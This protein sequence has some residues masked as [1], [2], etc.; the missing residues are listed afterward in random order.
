AAA[1]EGRL[2]GRRRALGG[3][4]ARE[5]MTRAPTAGQADRTLGRC[6]D[7]VASSRRFT[8]Y[9]V[10]EG[11]RPV[12]LLS[13]RSVSGVPRN[14]WDSRRVRDSMI[15]REEVPL[16]DEDDSAVDALAELSGNNVHR[17]L[18]V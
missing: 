14:E 6:M 10:L 13:F 7:A 1:A 4:R 11:G 17:G 5:L 2:G 3:V 12:G 9:P 15:P 18:V 8:P 16:L